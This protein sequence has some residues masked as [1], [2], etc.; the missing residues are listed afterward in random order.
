M[1]IIRGR[2]IRLAALQMESR[3]GS[4][5]ENLRTAVAMLRSAAE[6]G[7]NLACLPAAFATGMNLPSVRQDSTAA[8]G[9]IAEFLA[10]QARSLGMYIVAGVLLNE[11]RDVFDAAALVTPSGEIAGW[12]RRTCTWA[13]EAD[14]ISTGS[15]T[16]AIDTDLGR[17]GL[18]VGNDIR[19]PE[20]S[21]HYLLDSTDIIVT[22]ANLFAPYSH[23]VPSIVRA[24]AA[25]NACTI[26]FCD[27][28]GSNRFL[29]MPYFGRSMIVDGL[30]WDAAGA[31]D[32]DV[33][34]DAGPESWEALVHAEISLKMQRKTRD[35]TPFRTDAQT[36]WKT[37][38]RGRS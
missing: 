23:A 38:H 34:A 8:D 10:Q 26:V 32:A 2:K 1:S 25:D 20:A 16:P 21:R 18:L 12:Y 28:V 24:R 7:V 31:S 36:L 6:R 29:R 3:P 5:D 14:Y 4:R 30:V 13:G 17:I 33:L 11:D 22:V 15:V 27:S 35:K 19:Y 37:I 9:P